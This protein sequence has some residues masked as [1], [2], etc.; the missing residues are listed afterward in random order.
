LLNEETWK[1]DRATIQEWS[2][3]GEPADGMLESQARYAFAELLLAA[4]YSC[5]NRMPMKY[6]LDT[7]TLS[8]DSD[9]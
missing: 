9:C 7:S 6:Y 5:D 1:A 4:Q 3:A 8:P 2:E